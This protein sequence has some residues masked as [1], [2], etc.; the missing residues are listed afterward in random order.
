MEKYL[1][2]EREFYPSETGS[3]IPVP[4]ALG[5][6]RIGERIRHLQL[7]SSDIISAKCDR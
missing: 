5:Y 2:L 1:F 4:I 3:K 6:D 7:F